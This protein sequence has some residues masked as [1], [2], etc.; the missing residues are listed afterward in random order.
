M[1]QRD[2]EGWRMLEGTFF[3]ICMGGQGTI[4]T[5]VVDVEGVHGAKQATGREV[6]T[7]DI[8]VRVAADVDER[9]AVVLSDERTIQSPDSGG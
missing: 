4:V 1:C 3:H 6:G 8:V 2:P 5:L 9:V 7:H